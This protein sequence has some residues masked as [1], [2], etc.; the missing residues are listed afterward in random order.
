MI[1]KRD[2][3][4]WR[5]L[6]D[7]AQEAG[8]PAPTGIF[9]LGNPNRQLQDFPRTKTIYGIA[10]ALG[11]SPEQVATAALES[12]GLAPRTVME[13]DAELVQLR[14][15]DTEAELP[16][17]GRLIVIVPRSDT[18]E[19]ALLALAFGEGAKINLDR[20]RVQVTPA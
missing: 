16:Q 9:H 1:K 5:Q 17:S 10:A 19:Q 20:A 7:R 3:L 8:A 11:V 4:T 12:L 6:I 18:S 15:S 14:T 2:G 13:I